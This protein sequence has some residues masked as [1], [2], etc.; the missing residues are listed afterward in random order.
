MGGPN[1]ESFKMPGFVMKLMQLNEELV[2]GGKMPFELRIRSLAQS[3][4]Q[5]QD[6]AAEVFPALF[7]LTRRHY[8]SP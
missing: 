1:G 3:P 8:H 2:E 4:I 6:D 7:G 5:L